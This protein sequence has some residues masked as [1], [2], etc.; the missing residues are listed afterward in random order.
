MY[1]I[2]A[3]IICLLL[4]YSIYKYSSDRTVEYL[5]LGGIAVLLVV[6]AVLASQPQ[7]SISIQD[8]QDLI[9]NTQS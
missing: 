6:L 7:K 3:I 5:P 4:S 9:K 2:Y 8:V 1:I